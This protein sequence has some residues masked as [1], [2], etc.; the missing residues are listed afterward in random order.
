MRC[1]KS[2]RICPGY[3]DQ[4]EIRFRGVKLRKER[5]PRIDRQHNT[6]V[7][8]ENPIHGHFNTHSTLMPTALSIGTAYD[9]HAW[10]EGSFSPRVDRQSLQSLHL[11][12]PV[13][14]QAR[15]SFVT[16]FVLS[17][18]PETKRGHIDFIIP[19]LQTER[20]DSPLLL[21]FLAVGL[22]T[23]GTRPNSRA[24]LPKANQTYRQVLKK[25][26]LALIDRKSTMNDSILATVLLLTIY[27]VMLELGRLFYVSDIF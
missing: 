12:T 7:D 22:A 20:P 3:R 18:G 9:I 10:S 16:N 8:S 19:L 24:L 6:T 4:F 15:C 26:N 25:L 11:S 23:L 1:L 27:E 17:P 2:K 21:A 14:E 13:E 5:L